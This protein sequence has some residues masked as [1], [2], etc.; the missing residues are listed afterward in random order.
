M[1]T[2]RVDAY[3]AAL[4]KTAGRE[5]DA[6]GKPVLTELE[7]HVVVEADRLDFVDAF[8]RHV[9]VVIE[10]GRLERLDEEVG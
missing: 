6:A 7:A 3:L 10:L 1:T 5:F 8:K 2:S 4:S 9:A